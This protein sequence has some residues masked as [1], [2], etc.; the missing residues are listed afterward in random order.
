MSSGSEFKKTN[1]STSFKLAED[2]KIS[3]KSDLKY[4]GS[5]LNNC[6]ARVMKVSSTK[7]KHLSRSSD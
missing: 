2:G 3:E 5:L 1:L 4:S 7:K 6:L